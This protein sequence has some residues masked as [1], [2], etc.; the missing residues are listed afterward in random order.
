LYMRMVTEI[1]CQTRDFPLRLFL[2]TNA[3]QDFP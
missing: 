2:R 3:D 1:N